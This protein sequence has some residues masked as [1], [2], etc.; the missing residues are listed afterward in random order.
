MIKNK[1]IICISSIDW[2]F[3]WQGHQEIMSTFVKNG[4]R[5]LFIEN[6]GIRTPTFKDASRL[7]KRFINWIKSAKG[8]REEEKNLYIYSPLILPFP[9]SRL[10][11]FINKYLFINTLKRWI[12]ITKFFDPIIW[13][14][15]PTGTALDVISNIDSKFLVYYCIADFYKL[16]DSEKKVKKTENKL[17]EQSDLIFAQGRDFYNKCKVLNNNVFIFP[18]GVKFDVFK[19]F[20]NHNENDNVNDLVGIKRP[21]IG[22]VG[23]IHKHIDVELVKFISHQMPESSIVL[24][25]P[26]QINTCMLEKNENIYF[27][28]KK[29]FQDLPKYINSFDVC[30]VPYLLNDFTKTVYPTKLNEYH[31]LGKPVVSTA[32]PE[33]LNYNKD[34]D[35]IIAVGENYSDFV[36]KLRFMI[37]NKE[38]SLFIKKRISSA[39]KNNWDNRIE[40]M[41]SLIEKSIDEKTL[42]SNGWKDNFLS[43]YKTTKRNFVRILFIVVSFYFIIFY[44]PLIWFLA[45]PL[46]IVDFPQ[47]S[48]AIVVFAGGVGESGQPGQGYEERVYHAVQLYKK[49]LAKKIIFSSGYMYLFKEPLMMKILAMELGVP[50]HAIVIEDKAKN[51]FEN[52]IFTSK[53]LDDLNLNKIML[54][55]SPFHTLRSSL[56]FKK[57]SKN[58]EVIYTPL[59]KSKFYERN[60]DSQ[61]IKSLKKIQPHQIKGILHEYLAILFYLIKN[62]I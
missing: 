40:A 5:V 18:F 56:V 17:I 61:I 60:I 32:L 28:G 46:K 33:M 52:V 13:T 1:N 14:F 29:E 48:D 30:I 22:Y 57:V 55:T 36:K 43:L 37:L 38:D 49:G 4:N 19:E 12:K 51:T 23:G 31:A 47:A 54:V 2:D 3:V 35:N 26:K 10:A 11:S 50:R 16:A 59:P 41:S 21:I 34:N 6:T 8:F 62:Y 9:Y 27:L 45:N 39:K 7:K 58:I 42:S 25:G 24:V 53:I 15:L 44:T 20:S